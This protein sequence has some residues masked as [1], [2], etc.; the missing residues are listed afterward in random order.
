MLLPS[1]PKGGLEFLFTECFGFVG[2]TRDC[3]AFLLGTHIT[4]VISTA[5]IFPVGWSW[6]STIVS[7]FGA[8][9]SG[10]SSLV[11][12]LMTS[13]GRPTPFRINDRE[14]GYRLTRPDGKLVFVLG[15]YTTACGGLDA[16]F[17]YKGA[18]DDVVFCVNKLAAKGHVVCEGIIAM[19]SWGID[20]L[21]KQ[22]QDQKAKG[23]HVIYAL[24]SPPWEV[25]VD[26]LT[27][28][29]AASGRIRKT[30]FDPEKTVRAKHNGVPKKHAKL[31]AAGC[32]ARI[33]PWQDPLPSL[34]AWLEQ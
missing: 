26:R 8:N 33:L 17:S 32:D 6:M 10:K 18:A 30:P 14:A 21:V 13:F 4:E 11:R 20:R 1:T 5:A 7:I 22:A 25:V 27:K 29:Q 24:L 23:N 9:A 3:R 28:R 31:A 2:H 16:S 15:K 19:S 34:S 12:N